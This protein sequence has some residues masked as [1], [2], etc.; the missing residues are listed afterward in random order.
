MLNHNKTRLNM[1]EVKTGLILY[2]TKHEFRNISRQTV[3]AFQP[4]RS[5]T[6]CL[7]LSLNQSELNA[8][9][10]VTILLHIMKVNKKIYYE[11]IVKT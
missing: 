10:L 5:F 2:T 11:T 3:M 4:I 1:I 8:S 6:V 7:Q 9:E